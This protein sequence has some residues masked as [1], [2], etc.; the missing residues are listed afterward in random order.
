MYGNICWIYAVINSTNNSPV[1]AFIVAGVLWLPSFMAEMPM[2]YS[3]PGNRSETEQVIYQ[4]IHRTREHRFTVSHSHTGHVY[5]KVDEDFH[6]QH[7]YE[8]YKVMIYKNIFK[9]ISCNSITN[10]IKIY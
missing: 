3:V 7:S 2:P 4:S 8:L 5:Y 10:E 6:S 9:E 1:L